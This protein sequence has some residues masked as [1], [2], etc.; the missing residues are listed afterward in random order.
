MTQVVEEAP[1]EVKEEEPNH[2]KNPLPPASNFF[3]NQTVPIVAGNLTPSDAPAPSEKS[4][5]YDSEKQ[6]S[7]EWAGSQEG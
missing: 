3:A 6:K 4:E 5:E 2:L 1:E 7:E